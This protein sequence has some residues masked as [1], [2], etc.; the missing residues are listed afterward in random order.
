M[1]AGSGRL[2][3]ETRLNLYLGLSAVTV[4]TRAFGTLLSKIERNERIYEADILEQ[5]TYEMLGLN[6]QPALRLP[7]LQPY[8]EQQLFTLTY[9][10]RHCT[11]DYNR[12][13]LTK[14]LIEH[15]IPEF[16]K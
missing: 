16:D 8:D 1:T 11:A 13:R 12:H 5:T 6:R 4:L 7:G 9:L 10:Q 14:L 15:D 3:N 2:M